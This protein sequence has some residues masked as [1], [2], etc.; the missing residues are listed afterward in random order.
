M[1]PFGDSDDEESMS[2]QVQ[3]LYE[4][5]LAFTSEDYQD[6]TEIGMGL[7]GSIANV[8]QDYCIENLKAWLETVCK[9][10]G[11]EEVPASR[12]Y[13]GL[14]M[15]DFTLHGVG[16]PADLGWHLLDQ[17][18]LSSMWLNVCIGNRSK[19]K[20]SV[21][22]RN[23][24]CGNWNGTNKFSPVSSVWHDSCHLEANYSERSA[25][26]EFQGEVHDDSKHLLS[27]SFWHI[28]DFVLIDTSSVQSPMVYFTLRHPPKLTLE[29]SLPTEPY[30]VRERIVKVPSDEGGSLGQCHVYLF[31]VASDV[32]SQ[33]LNTL[34]RIGKRVWFAHVE[35]STKDEKACDAQLEWLKS[36]EIPK[37][38]DAAHYAWHCVI[39]TPGYWL[40]RFEEFF[41]KELSRLKYF[42]ATRFLYA[43]ADELQNDMFST[44]TS[45]VEKS[46]LSRWMQSS[47]DAQENL[48]WIKR[49]IITPT[50]ILYCNPDPMQV[51]I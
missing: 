21:H 49:V 14:R 27:F 45:L 15:V 11:F 16:K 36:F 10:F 8:T 35:H 44:T 17:W 43:L 50:R 9:V 46:K 47:S 12:A 25:H 23:L 19:A 24:R 28:M 31:T 34:A 1:Q 20:P 13:A 42:E 29:T 40:G 26:F 4:G 2:S 7:D 3:N 5:A 6:E 51:C 37:S 41:W 30:A 48:A 33:L 18:R 39:S 32:L 38:D 22:I